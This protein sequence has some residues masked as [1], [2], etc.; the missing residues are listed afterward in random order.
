MATKSKRPS[1]AGL[2]DGYKTMSLLDLFKETGKIRRQWYGK[3]MAYD[4]KQSLVK[5]EPGITSGSPTEPVP[6]VQSESS[7]PDRPAHK[8]HSVCGETGTDR[9][10]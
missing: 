4:Q 3:Q 6:C 8:P 7:E 10:P 5:I 9:E 2:F 1:Q